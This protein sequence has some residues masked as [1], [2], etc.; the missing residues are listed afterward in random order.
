MSIF[1]SIREFIREK[2][3][4][5]FTS[6]AALVIVVLICV[7]LLLIQYFRRDDAVSPLSI[8]GVVVIP[9]QEGV[10]RAGNFLFRT[11]QERLSLNEA[12]DRIKEL[13]GEVASLQRELDGLQQI[14]VENAELRAL[15]SAAEQYPE[16][17]MEEAL[18]IGNDGVNS[19]E[20]FTINKGT[21]D[22]IRVNMNVIN[23][24]GLIGI[25]TYTGLNY[26]VV[27]SIIEDGVNVS[28]MTKNGHENCIVTGDLLHSGTERL[29]LENALGDVDFSADSTLLTS[30]ISDRFLPG[31]LIGYAVDVTQNEGGLTQS[32][33]VTTA[34]DFNRLKEVLVITTMREAL[35]DQEEKK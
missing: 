14:S 24:D 12:K 16:Y 34:V 1:A 29:V 19:F 2:I 11:E 25:V 33:Y 31:L 7:M 18:I 8:A 21:A 3:L 22:G 4:S 5:R 28:A 35:Q 32:G 26:A 10:N 15:L 13:E 17:E 30:N 27:T 23:Q 6:R 20:R 9:F